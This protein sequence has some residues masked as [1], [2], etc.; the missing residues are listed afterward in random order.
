MKINEKHVGGKFEDFLKEQGIHDE[1]MELASKKRLVIQ[2]EKYMKKKGITKTSL[3]KKLNTS[4]M[5]VNRIL[6]PDHLAVSF[7]TLNHAAN[8]IGCRINVELVEN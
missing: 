4:R 1:V 3:A 5:Q 8:A 2:F 6:S 7:E